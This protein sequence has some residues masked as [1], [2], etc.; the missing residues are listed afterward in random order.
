MDVVK[1]DYLFI[2][3]GVQTSVVTM[4]IN[5]EVPQKEYDAGIPL[6]DIISKDSISCYLCTHAD[7]SIYN[8]QDIQTTQVSIY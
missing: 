2:L 3:I 6:L 4:E 8:I 1:E 5:L 7:F